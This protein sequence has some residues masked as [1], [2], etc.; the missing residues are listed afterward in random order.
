MPR[1]HFQELPA[2][3]LQAV[4]DKTG[5]VQSARTADGGR[6]SGIAAF[7]DTDN[8][9]VFV[10]GVPAGHPQA[11]AQQREA[12]INPHLPRAC[13]RLYWHIEVDGWILLGYET[14]T[15]RQADYTPGSPDLPLVAT[16]I[17][18]L[19]D[20]TAPADIDIK[21]AEQR[22]AAY[23][24]PGAAGL[25]AGDTLLHTD[26]APDNILIDQRAHIIDWAWPTRGA[27]W[28]DPAVMILRLMEAG[29]TA[30]EADA[31]ARS[32]PSWQ[33]ADP[34]A[35]AAFAAANAAL[36]RTI[37]EE[38]KSAWKQSMAIQAVALSAFLNRR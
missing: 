2:E 36:W 5:S 28:I 9:P 30:E 31:F 34:A 19:Q 11:P 22:W 18:E 37:A 6:N 1:R 29:G 25:F 23:A 15:G 32:L 21:A 16:A 35:K 4:A 17:A 7:L 14:L 8:G 13:P 20:V 24:P 26:L 38:D 3:V 27:A 10:K 33:A 12:A